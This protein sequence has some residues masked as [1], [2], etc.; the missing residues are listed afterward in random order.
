MTNRVGWTIA[1]ALVGGLGFGFTVASREGRARHSTPRDFTTPPTLRPDA[2]DLRVS[3]VA[4]GRE[5]P[6]L[7]VPAQLR[8]WPAQSA[9]L[10]EPI[11]SPGPAP[12]WTQKDVDEARANGHAF[13]LVA[14]A[15]HLDEEL[16]QQ[17]VNIERT[18]QIEDE[19]QR[20][21]SS[22]SLRARFE[23]ATCS[24]DLCRVVVVHS[25]PEQRTNELNTLLGNGP[26]DGQVLMV[27]R[28]APDNESV[29]YFSK[30]GASLPLGIHA[31]PE[32]AKQTYGSADSDRP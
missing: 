15:H 12:L 24:D 10:I 3:R 23:G 19:L 29:L 16:Y 9:E 1:L 26:L 8:A 21:A 2:N 11:A 27:P 32:L 7:S 18:T 14:D 13:P 17:P 4:L 28:P 25:A 6:R 31:D 5:P 20:S 22:L 30:Q